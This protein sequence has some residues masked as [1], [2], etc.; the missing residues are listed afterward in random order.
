MLGSALG[1]GV[2]SGQREPRTSRRKRGWAASSRP[3][4]SSWCNP[5]PVQALQYFRHALDEWLLTVKATTVVMEAELDHH[6]AQHRRCRH[7]CCKRCL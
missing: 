2:A 4:T 5:C 7:I 6:C 3:R 1:K